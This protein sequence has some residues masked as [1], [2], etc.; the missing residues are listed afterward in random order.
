M[1][2]ILTS[3]VWLCAGTIVRAFIDNPAVFK[4]GVS[5]VKARL[6]SGPVIGILF[7][8]TNAL[9]A[10]GAA[11]KSLILSLTRQGFIFIPLLIIL[12]ATIG[13]TGIIYSQAIADF[14]SILISLA[15][16]HLNLK[17]SWKEPIRPMESIKNC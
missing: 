7:A 17:R 5:F 3:A 10:M 1:G 9:Q 16:Y 6:L 11:G 13:L 12:D 2:I 8:Y 4:Y 15:L 14:I